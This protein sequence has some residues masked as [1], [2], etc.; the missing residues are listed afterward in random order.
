[1]FATGRAAP[2]DG[3]PW[4][5]DNGAFTAWKGGRP[6]DAEAFRARVTHSLTLAT[7]PT[8]A[9]LPDVVGAGLDSLATSL[10]WLDELPPLPWFLAVQD[11]MSE[12][13]V[14]PHLPR[15]AGLFLGGTDAFKRTARRW[16][17]LAHAHGKRFH[18]ARV[19][20]HAR[21]AAAHDMG[22]DSCDSSQPLWSED[23][24]ARF[25][26]WCARTRNG[27]MSLDI[28]RAALAAGKEDGGG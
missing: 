13:D 4:G 21:L 23:H 22:A 6:F 18:F 7:P 26:S 17:S 5:L 1:M 9:V 25:E 16:C 11:G 27:Q 19:S 14:E 2:Y 3:E 24:W 10:A 15:L 8:V 12:A 20:T 28:A